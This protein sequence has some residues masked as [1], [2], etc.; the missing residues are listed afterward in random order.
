MYSHAEGRSTLAGSN[1]NGPYAAHAEGEYTI[2]A[3]YGCHAEGGRTS[4][5]GTPLSNYS[6]ESGVSISGSYALGYNS[7]AEGCQTYAKGYVSH[8]EGFQTTASGNYSHAEGYKAQALGIGS[9]AEGGDHKADGTHRDPFSVVSQEAQAGLLIVG[10]RAEGNDSH[11]EGIQTYAEGAGSHAEG[12]QTQTSGGCSHAEGWQTFTSSTASHAEGYKATA[13]GSGAH[14]EG[15]KTT[16]SGQYS[17]AEGIS[18][19]ASG[20]SSHA[21]GNETV[22]SG[23]YSH[24]GG[25]GTIAS[26][27]NNTVIGKY[28]ID[29]RN[30]PLHIGAGASNN[31]RW[32]SFWVNWEGNLNISHYKVDGDS[33]TLDPLGNGWIDATH[34]WTDTLESALNIWARPSDGGFHTWIRQRTANHHYAMGLIPSVNG[35][36]IATNPAGANPAVNGISKMLN[37]N[38]ANGSLSISGS[39]SQGSDRRLKNIYG[40]ITEE[41]TLAILEGVNIV[42]YSYKYDDDVENNIRSGIIAQDLQQILEEHNIENRAYLTTINVPR[43]EALIESIENE[44][45]EPWSEDEM[46]KEFLG[47]SYVD[48]VPILIKGWQIHKQKMEELKEENRFLM[49]RLDELEDKINAITGI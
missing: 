24:A 12:C 34:N 9:H 25:E 29:D 6:P 14:A 18:T 46:T 10:P 16:A 19:T 5:D 32:T 22:A 47:I 13:S 17:H 41:E 33:Y 36:Y 44:E 26:Y 42:N 30:A 1:N 15:F 35:F 31:V 20:T 11:A 49:R 23:Y 8:A 37:W 28:N 3:S 38:G 27:D 40:D 48:L 39:L 7:H 21:E 2:A 45:E 43:N 4:V